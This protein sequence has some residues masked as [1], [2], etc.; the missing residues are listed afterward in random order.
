M[1]R[2]V[3]WRQTPGQSHM[4]QSNEAKCAEEKR[5]FAELRRTLGSLVEIQRSYMEALTLGD[6]Q[7][8]R[9]EEEICAIGLAGRPTPT[10]N[11][12]WI[13]ATGVRVEEIKE[14][15]GGRA[16]G[17][18]DLGLILEGAVP[19][20]LD[21]SL[22]DYAEAMQAVPDDWRPEPDTRDL[23]AAYVRDVRPR[24]NA[25]NAPLKRY[26]AAKA[27]ASWTAY[28]GHG[29]LTIVR[30]LE[31]ALALVRV[32]AT[33]QCRDAGRPLDAALL[34]EAFRQA[35]FVLNHLAAGDE[36]ADTWSKVE[37]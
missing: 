34:R 32:E 11:T 7:V 23:A 19:A 2:R 10:S 30:G 21:S 20:A 31:A 6:P 37:A 15:G 22:A 24:W 14:P 28:Q 3:A 36:L 33:R 16:E 9:F 8:F 17:L 35:D 5:L 18:A 12:F 29:F 4:L 26:L 25:W 13:T 1:G 27:F